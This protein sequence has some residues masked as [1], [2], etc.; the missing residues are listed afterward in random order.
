M[1]KIVNRKKEIKYISSALSVKKH[2][3]IYGPIG[4]GKTAFLH[5]IYN[6]IKSKKNLPIYIELPITENFDT[7][8]KIIAEKIDA[9]LHGKNYFLNFIEYVSNNKGYNADYAIILFSEALNAA[10]DT[11]NIVLCFDNTEKISRDIWNDFEENILRFHLG[12]GDEADSRLRIITAGQKRMQWTFFRMR[13]QVEACCLDLLDRDSTKEMIQLL[14]SQERIDLDTEDREPII[15]DIYSLTLGHPKSIKL[16]IQYWKELQLA[17]RKYKK[18]IAELLIEKFIQPEII[19]Q[20]NE[21]KEGEHYPP[22]ETLL[23]LLQHLTP[24]RFISTKILRETLPHISPFSSFYNKK[25][26]FFFNKLLRSLVAEHLLDWSEER[27]RYEFPTIVQ[28]ILIE[29]LKQQKIE[30]LIKIHQ[31]IEKVYQKLIH[32]NLV[33]RNADFIEQIYH[34]ISWQEIDNAKRKGEHDLEETLWNKI[35][36]YLKK[37]GE[38]EASLENLLEKDDYFKNRVNWK[39]FFRSL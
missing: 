1:H 31:E 27:E 33:D 35:G 9:T 39:S 21:L 24:L 34:A 8:L 3:D 6:Y 25:R 14:A 12:I 38:D 13:E 26:P 16:I 30:N 7:F 18:G 10:T 19:D 4:I 20:A 17:D 29:D 32:E 23:S 36:E 15:D 2:L 28:H 22:S 37:Y 5:F 11:I